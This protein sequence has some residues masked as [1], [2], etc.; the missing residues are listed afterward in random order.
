M[1]VYVC[2]CM[3]LVSGDQQLLTKPVWVPDSSC[4]ECMICN[5]KF[6]HFIRKH[7]CRQCGRVICS[8]CS[9]YRVAWDVNSGTS[10]DSKKMERIC[11]DCFKDR[12]THAVRRSSELVG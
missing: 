6:T 3:C 9:P 12:S 2:V 7:H 11:K 5:I 8:S 1:Y 4:K 10:A